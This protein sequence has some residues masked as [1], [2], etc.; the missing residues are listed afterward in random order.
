M[1]SSTHFDKGLIQI[2]IGIDTIGI[3]FPQLDD[4]A[5]PLFRDDW[6]GAVCF[7]DV[8]DGSLRVW[9]KVVDGKPNGPKSAQVQE[10]K[11]GS[12]M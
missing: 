5:W 11:S 8:P 3:L 1:W 9:W 6:N 12:M 4:E 2:V 10:Y 7:G